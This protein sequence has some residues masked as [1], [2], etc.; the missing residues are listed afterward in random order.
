MTN[1]KIQGANASS[2]SPFRS[3][4]EE[5]D[6]GWNC[7]NSD[8]N[9]T[10]LIICL[11]RVDTVFLKI[12]LE[13][14]YAQISTNLRQCLKYL[15]DDF[16]SAWPTNTSDSWFSP[17]ASLVQNWLI[18]QHRSCLFSEQCCLNSWDVNS[19]GAFLN[20]SSQFLGNWTTVRLIVFLYSKELTLRQSGMTVI[21]NK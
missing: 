5:T 10:G 20:R 12:E 9:S 11:Q 2:C 1:F 17:C 15:F 16:A 19:R 8:F 6:W 21:R 3:P 13:K 4:W 7:T 18:P 14:N